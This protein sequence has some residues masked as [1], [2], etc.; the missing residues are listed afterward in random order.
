[1]S[2]RAAG[3]PVFFRMVQKY[4]GGGGYPLWA[5]G[6]PWLRRIWPSGER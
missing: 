3:W 1:M 2:T 6:G 4:L 5:V